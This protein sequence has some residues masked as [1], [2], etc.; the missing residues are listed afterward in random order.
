MTKLISRNISGHMKRLHSALPLIWG[1]W[2]ISYIFENRFHLF[3][4]FGRKFYVW[5]PHDAVHSHLN[6]FSFA[7]TIPL[8]ML[9]VVDITPPFSTNNAVNSY[10]KGFFAPYNPAQHLTQFTCPAPV[11]GFECFQSSHS[12]PA[13]FLC[14]N[15][16]RRIHREFFQ[17]GATINIS[18]T[19]DRNRDLEIL[20]DSPPLNKSH[21]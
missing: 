11:N 7:P 13:F 15:F 9:V 4:H 17:D 20:Y 10:Q 5:R 14:S 3:K 6:G 2:L 12:C 21:G 1:L 19:S 8:Y 16:I 18:S